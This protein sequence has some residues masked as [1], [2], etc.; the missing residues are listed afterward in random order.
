MNM[1]LKKEIQYVIGVDE[2]GRGPLAGPVT[3]GVFGV[4]RSFL[5]EFKKIAKKLGITD[6]KKLAEKRRDEIAKT[7]CDM[8]VQGNCFFHITMTPASYIDTHGIVSAIKKSLHTALG[9]VIAHY[10]A[11]LD[12]TQIFL[13]GGLF[14]GEAYKNQQTIIKGDL[15][16]ILISAASILAKVHRDTYMK[17]MDKKYP[18]YGFA[19]HV[20]YGT[21]YHRD[22]IKKYGFSILHRKSFCKNIQDIKN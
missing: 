16:N 4:E 14:A 19:Q 7:L 9:K 3:V 12:Q 15:H 5:Q 11:S 10:G 17:R 22:M 8:T 1:S 6:S 20:G 18:Q 2:V 13:D 21:Q